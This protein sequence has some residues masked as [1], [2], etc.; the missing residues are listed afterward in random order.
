[1]SVWT[2]RFVGRMTPVNVK[3]PSF[4]EAVA[5]AVEYAK[6]NDIAEDAILAVDYMAY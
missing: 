1:M 6:K 3:A 4:V 2:V 5:K